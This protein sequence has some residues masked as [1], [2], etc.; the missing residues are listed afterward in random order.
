ME[1]IYLDHNATTPV[2]REVREAMLPYL[3]ERFGNPS[4]EYALGLEARVAVEVARRQ[5]AAL[6][7]VRSD[8]VIFTSG[9]TEANNLALIGALRAHGVARA[10]VVTSA[11]EHPAVLKPLEALEREGIRITHVPPRHDGSIDP[12]AFIE[13]FRDETVLVSLMHS[14]NEL[15]TLQPVAEIA[16]EARRRGILVHTDAAQSIGKVAVDVAALGVDLLSFAGHKL[17]APKG[18]GAL[19]VRPGA[20]LVPLLY[21]GGQEH[22]FRP[23]TEPVPSIVGLGVACALAEADLAEFGP[24]VG[25]LR[26]LLE[27]RLVKDVPDVQINGAGAARLPSTSHV[28]FLSLD[29]GALLAAVP[30]LM[31]STGSACHTGATEP[32]HV[33]QSLGASEEAARGAVRFSLGRHTTRAEI[34]RAADLIAAAATRPAPRRDAPAS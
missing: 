27:Q 31:A 19:W 24:R 25:A 21:G 9:G 14:N 16:R 34:E 32:S 5:V 20:Q 2:A 12:D 6:I 3:G 18:I 26:D 15:G 22:G 29:G 1:P 13:E 23:G 4:S 8:D 7:G 33:L 28:S 10:H 30:D 17:Y 11:I